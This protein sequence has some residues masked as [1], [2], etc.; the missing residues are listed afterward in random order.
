MGTRI[1]LVAV[2]ALASW[3]ARAS[4]SP[5]P[6]SS[7]SSSSYSW[8][9][10]AGPVIRCEP[11]DARARALCKPEPP[12]C[13]ERVREPGCGC[14][15]TCALREGASCGVYRGRCG[16]GLA[17]RHGPE[18]PKPLLALL[19]GRAVCVNASSSRVAGGARATARIT[20]TGRARAL[21][22]GDVK[23]SNGG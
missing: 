7:S 2:T 6:P 18:E 16:A 21:G 9:R 20:S 22:T 1:L 10:A 19:E 11:C 15:L 4:S 14:C 13:A 23:V 3:L 12:E 17:C 8:S 5:S